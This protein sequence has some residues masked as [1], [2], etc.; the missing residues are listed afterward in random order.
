MLPYKGEGRRKAQI[1]FACGS[2]QATLAV[3]G[4]RMT[5]LREMVPKFS[6]IARTVGAVRLQSLML[7]PVTEFGLLL[8]VVPIRKAPSVSLPLQWRTLTES[9][10]N[11]GPPFVV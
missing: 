11:F 9:M 6:A 2:T 3:H 8:P 1:R 7:K 4:L 5:F 10:L